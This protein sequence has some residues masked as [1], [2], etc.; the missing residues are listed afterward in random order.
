MA[1]I[2]T[3][4][5]IKCKFMDCV[6]ICPVLCFHEGENMLVIDP[7]ECIDCAACVDECP[8]NAIYVDRDVPP[9]WKEYVEIN[10]RLAAQWPVIELKSEPPADGDSWKGVKNK[11]EH[12]SEK[13]GAGTPK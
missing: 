1:Y 6:E 9:Q 2:V 8:V 12:L 11:R 5:C 4:P 13:P 10:K 3:E 7:I